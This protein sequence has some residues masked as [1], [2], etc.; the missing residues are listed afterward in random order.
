[1]KKFDA[2]LEEYKKMGI[3][4]DGIE[5]QEIA[6]EE[7]TTDI[8]ELQAQIAQAQQQQPQQVPTQQ[9]PNQQIPTQQIPIQ[10]I[11]SQ[12]KISPQQI[13]QQY[14]VQQS[15][16]QSITRESLAIN[17]IVNFQSK[18]ESTVMNLDL[19]TFTQYFQTFLR[20]HRQYQNYV[21]YLNTNMFE[22]RQ[23][24]I[25]QYTQFMALCDQI[26]NDI[27]LGAFK[28]DLQTAVNQLNPLTF[29]KIYKCSEIEYENTISE[30]KSTFEQQFQL[31]TQFRDILLQNQ[32]L[33][34]RKSNKK[35][36]KLQLEFIK[37]QLKRTEIE[38][39][40]L[41]NMDLNPLP[42]TVQEDFVIESGENKDIQKNTL[43]I[44][45]KRFLLGPQ[46]KYY[47][48]IIIN[49]ISYETNYS[50]TN[51][52]INYQQDI[53]IDPK[54]LL[55][56]Q[57]EIRIYRRK[58]IVLHS[59][60]LATTLNLSPLN[61][62]YTY[63]GVLKFPRPNYKDCQLEFSFQI[64]EPIYKQTNQMQFSIMHLSKTF[65]P[66]NINEG[67]G[68]YEGDYLPKASNIFESRR[69][70]QEI[71]IQN[72]MQ[73]EFTV[74]KPQQVVQTN[75]NEQQLLSDGAQKQIQQPQQQLKPQEQQI[76]QPEQ[77]MK[78]PEQKQEVQPVQPQKEVQ[79]DEE[80]FE[81]EIVI[82]KPE[83]EQLIK[84][85]EDKLPNGLSIE[86]ALSF[87]SPQ[88]YPIRKFIKIYKTCIVKQMSTLSRNERKAINSG[89]QTDYLK[90]EVRI[91]NLYKLNKGKEHILQI[92]D[93]Q[94][95]HAKLITFFDSINLK[96]YSALIQFRQ[97]ILIEELAANEQII[98]QIKQEREVER[99][100]K[101]K[102]LVKHLQEEED[103][104]KAKFEQVETQLT[105]EEVLYPE[106]PN[107]SP[108]STFCLN[109]QEIL[110]YNSNLVSEQWRDR[111]IN[112]FKT[113]I[114][115]LED[116]SQQDDGMEKYTIIVKQIV[117]RDQLLLDFYT[118]IGLKR[119]LIVIENR[120][121]ACKEDLQSME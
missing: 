93:L 106:D 23:A 8:Q 31:L 25:Q 121:N 91:D 77:Q 55:N 14:P 90:E 74:I 51:G 20:R 36:E 97:K 64:R 5:A 18:F 120:I 70:V 96:N 53:Q 89:I 111:V 1:M 4:V 41:N 66:F 39:D 38:L 107:K 49:Q 16:S 40:F 114:N 117:E 2:M 84:D 61:W 82:R 76:K 52:I 10:Q 108:C 42:I 34:V 85:N 56:Q 104:V 79:G 105:L 110:N 58:M 116:L 101:L 37:S 115:F 72:I 80:G 13:P 73:S 45:F 112:D 95:K 50:D 47:I 87:D 75:N 71:Q 17:Q 67:V 19:R 35:T 86:D 103:F 30:L 69:S 46:E 98:S 3:D 63:D 27:L 11:P 59:E 60:K 78:A 22:V 88:K 43:R 57:I 102:L 68:Q 92:I 54:Q 7:D 32:V 44:R 9:I 12:Q 26:R 99:Q 113:Q 6:E 33:M 24:E 81:V 48:K 94:E 21:E 83:E 28:V 100:N 29:E 119:W 109:Y 118:K 65:P 15:K 62:S